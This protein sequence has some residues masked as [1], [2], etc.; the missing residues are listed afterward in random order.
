[1][2][3]SFKNSDAETILKGAVPRGVSADLAKAAR[4][5][6]AQLDAAL[7][8][9]DMAVPPG[10]RLHKVGEAVWAIRVNDQFR[11]TFEWRSAGPEEV[12]FGD[13]H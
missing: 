5:R 4:R 12:W 9:S 11:I 2:I 7:Q 1:M 10:N 3:Q 6:L 13:Y 8:P